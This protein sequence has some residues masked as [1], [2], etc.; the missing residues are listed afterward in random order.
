MYAVGDVIGDVVA[1]VIGDGDVVADIIP[2]AVVVN[3]E[4]VKAGNV[5]ATVADVASVSC[6]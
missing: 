5:T 3:T 1:D 2:V 4:E 6:L